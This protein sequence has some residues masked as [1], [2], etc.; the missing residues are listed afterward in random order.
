MTMA[1]VIVDRENVNDDFVIVRRLYKESGSLVAADDC[2]LEIETSKT[3][4]EIL[5]PAAGLLSITL[6][7]GDE[8]AVGELLFEVAADAPLPSDSPTTTTHAAPSEDTPAPIATESKPNGQRDFSRAAAELAQRLGIAAEALP[9][10][11]IVTT[12]VLDAAGRGPP[13]EAQPRPT[14]APAAAA[15]AHGPRAAPSTRFR[16]ERMTLRKRT[17]AR[18]MARANGSGTSSMIGIEVLLPGPR[19]VAAPFLFH[20]SIADLIVFEAARL[21]RRFP[22]LNAFYL[23]ERTIGHFEE[24]NFGISFDKGH[25]LKV[26]TLYNADTLSLAQVQSGIEHLLH[27]YESDAPIE[28]SLMNSST[29][30]ISDLSRSPADFMLP[31]LNADQSFIIGVSRRGTEKYALHAA[32]DHRVS[33]GLQV[34]KFLGEL[35]ERV[36]SHHRPKVAVT[37]NLH[38]LRCSVCEQRLQQEL[39]LGSSVLMR[40]VLTDGTDGYLCRNCFD[41]W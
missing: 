35:R 28:A 33:E 34:A 29:V 11:W 32:F 12:D 41:G 6:L 14:E 17:E 38:S 21:L 4:R 3:I 36:E 1:R 8:V 22:D 23:D 24:V 18:N 7:E 10:G 31:L 5:S 37:N 40:V 20:D 19:L 16:E 39:N 26:L 15:K 2:V 9:G 25:D 13:R 30:T 27:L